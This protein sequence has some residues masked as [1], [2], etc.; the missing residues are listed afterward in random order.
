MK[1]IVQIKFDK[2]I[3]E[4]FQQTLKPLRFRKK[5]NNFY[6]FQNGIGH[7]INIQKSQYGSND[8]IKFTINTGIF[9]PEFWSAFYNYFDKV[10]PNFPT[11]SECILRMRIGRLKTQPDLWYDINQETEEM[12]LIE[13][14]RRNLDKFILPHFDQVRSKDMLVDMLDKQT[15]T[16]PLEKLIVFGELGH[17]EKATREFQ[18]L[19]SEARNP[20]FQMTVEEY[21]RKYGL[22]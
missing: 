5:A 15:T 3:H 12:F 14:M 21:G 16:S 1:S 18:R 9:L 19:L 22:T 17:I 8:H 7:I 11:E 6:L 10:V 20:H 13:E 4:G 2:I